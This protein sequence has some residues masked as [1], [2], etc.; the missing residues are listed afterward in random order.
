MP[1]EGKKQGSGIRGQ[2][3][4]VKMAEKGDKAKLH[5]V[6]FRMYAEG[7]SLTEIEATLGV[8]RQTLAKWK[9][10]SKVPSEELD[11]W[12]KARQVKRDSTQRLQDLFHRQLSY[13]EE[14]RPDEITAPMM[15]TMA[16][17]GALVER[18]DKF[19]AA[20]RK[21]ERDLLREKLDAATDGGK[22]VLDAARIKE[23]REQLL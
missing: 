22:K 11:A 10:D 18:W 16:K 8:S 13:I 6:A 4:G 17:L 3:S 14:L 9:A 7:K 12:D 21:Q 23:L 20:I 15:D 2:E 1:A 5:D 19:I